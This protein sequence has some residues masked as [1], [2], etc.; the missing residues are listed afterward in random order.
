ME[1]KFDSKKYPEVGSCIWKLMQDGF[2]V[3]VYK[4]VLRA[5][6]TE[7][8]YFGDDIV[9]D[10]LLHYSSPDGEDVLTIS[11]G[12]LVDSGNIFQSKE[13]LFKAIDEMV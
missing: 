1:Y 12:K 4:F 3:K 2:I 11:P 5:I 8:K 9:A 7:V 13:E 10:T 6:K